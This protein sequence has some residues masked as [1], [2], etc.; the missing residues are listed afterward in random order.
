MKALV[1]GFNKGFY[2]ER[3]GENISVSCSIGV[4]I[5]KADES[6]HESLIEDADEAMYHAKENGKNAYF[7]L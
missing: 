2:N 1:E 4:T 7:I 6:T 3:L 5:A